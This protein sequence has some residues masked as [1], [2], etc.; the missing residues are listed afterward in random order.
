MIYGSFK[1]FLRTSQKGSLLI[2]RIGLDIPERQLAIYSPGAYSPVIEMW[3]VE[4]EHCGNPSFWVASA[5]PD[6]T[7]IEMSELIKDKLVFA[8]SPK[9]IEATWEK[10]ITPQITQIMSPVQV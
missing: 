8:C 1:I 10:Q 5:K 7:G 6:V 2:H 4:V 3:I 9:W